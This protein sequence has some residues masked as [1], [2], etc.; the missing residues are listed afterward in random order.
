MQP[1]KHIFICLLIVL[2]ACDYIP[3][4][5][6]YIK[7]TGT[8]ASE[9]TMLLSEFTGIGCVNCPTAHLVAQRLAESYEGRLVVVEMHPESN[10]FTQSAD[11]LYDY[12]CPEADE[13]YKTFGGTSTTAFPTAVVDLTTTNNLYF[14]DYTQWATA[15]M[16]RSE[17]PSPI[18]LTTALSPDHRLTAAITNNGQQQA[19]NIILW[20]VEDSIEGRQLMPD[21]TVNDHYLHRHILR[22]SLNG[23]WGETVNIAADQTT[24]YS[25]DVSDAL[26][27]LLSGGDAD[28]RHLSI[29]TLIYSQTDGVLAVTQTSLKS[30]EEQEEPFILTINSVGTIRN[31][32]AITIT[33]SHTDPISGKQ[34]M[35][36]R[37]QIMMARHI[38]VDV[39]RSLENRDDQLCIGA[40]INGN[41]ERTQRFE[42]NIDTDLTS[43]FAHYYPEDT[44]PYTVLYHF[45]TTGRQLNLSITYQP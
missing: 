1:Y 33:D 23:T 10:N 24:D 25:L 11:P 8:A 20:L 40:C 7:Y 31:D 38:V 16:Q 5:E 14:V 35:E 30:A 41:G 45:Q 12:T 21:G 42:F 32:T 6:R 18:E 15:L 43:W 13:Y 9:R 29:V 17:T 37:G 36:C 44:Q 19:A 3:E 4:N 22:S 27:D 2:A 28:E 34:E 39:Q 26:S